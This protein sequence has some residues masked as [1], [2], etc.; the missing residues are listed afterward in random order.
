MQT[1]GTCTKLHTI[2]FHSHVHNQHMH[3]CSCR[4]CTSLCLSAQTVFLSV[5]SAAIKKKKKIFFVLF[6]IYTNVEVDEGKYD[7]VSENAITLF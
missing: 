6:I 4:L 5:L 7:R 1:I 2:H 3:L